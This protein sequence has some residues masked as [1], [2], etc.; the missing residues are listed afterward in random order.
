MKMY[1]HMLLALA[2]CSIVIN[3]KVFSEESVNSGKVVVM[4]LGGE[5]LHYGFTNQLILLGLVVELGCSLNAKVIA[6]EF[7]LE[8]GKADIGDISQ[9]LNVEETNSY[10]GCTQILPTNTSYSPSDATVVTAMQ[11]VVKNGWRFSDQMTVS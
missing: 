9:Y 2:I 10:L 3:S 1:G 11:M 8:I 4:H 6:P 5:D 7:K